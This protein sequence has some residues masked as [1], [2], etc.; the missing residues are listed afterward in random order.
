MLCEFEKRILLYSNNISIFSFDGMVLKYVI[1]TFQMNHSIKSV[2]ACI[3]S[4][5]YAFL[6]LNFEFDPKSV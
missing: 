4:E 6:F 3:V 1:S 2:S 5:F